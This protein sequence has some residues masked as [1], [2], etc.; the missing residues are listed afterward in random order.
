[1]NAK[2]MTA[3]TFLASRSRRFRKFMPLL[4]LAPLALGAWKYLQ[5]RKARKQL[6]KASPPT[7]GERDAA[8][9]FRSG[10]PVPSFR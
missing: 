7:Y 3:L 8:P 5:R 4:T 9:R 6:A 2:V 10:E 1:M